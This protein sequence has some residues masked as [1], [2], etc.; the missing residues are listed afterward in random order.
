MFEAEA[1]TMGLSLRL[2]PTANPI[3][4]QNYTREERFTGEE[5]LPE[6]KGLGDNDSPKILYL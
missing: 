6:R 2:A 1:M 3:P 4:H 5:R